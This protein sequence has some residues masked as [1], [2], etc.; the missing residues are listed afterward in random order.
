MLG[1]DLRV[2]G[3]EKAPALEKLTSRDIDNKSLNV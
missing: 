2:R 3:E 1:T